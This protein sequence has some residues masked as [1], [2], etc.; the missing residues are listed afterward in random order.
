MK[1]IETRQPDD[2][3]RQWAVVSS[4]PP[5][6]T[7]TLH[8]EIAGEMDDTVRRLLNLPIGLHFRKF[9]SSWSHAK[10]FPWITELL[11]KCSDN[12]ECLDVPCN[13]PRKLTLRQSFPSPHLPALV[14]LES[15]ASI[16]FSKATGLKT[17]ALRIESL[18]LSVRW[19]DM[20]LRTIVPEHQHLREI[21][22]DVSF[23]LGGSDIREA[24][25]EAAFG[26]WLDLDHVF[27]QP[28]ESHSIHPQVQLTIPLFLQLSPIRS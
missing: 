27:V 13:V 11:R 1:G 17:V 16:D 9:V 25:G 18:S 20:A 7:G 23:S 8:L 22:I 24:M 26:Y 10:D 14:D 3:H 15:E 4:A 5:P 12:L 21:S 2:H 28:W 19:I 6:L